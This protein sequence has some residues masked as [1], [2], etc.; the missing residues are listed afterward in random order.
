VF[1]ESLCDKATI[2]IDFEMRTY[3]TEQARKKL[4]P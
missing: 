1:C 2:V 3:E 4:A